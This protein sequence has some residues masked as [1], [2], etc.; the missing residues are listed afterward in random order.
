MK[1]EGLRT[2]YLMSAHGIICKRPRLQ[3]EH[4]VQ[5]GDTEGAR[6]LQ[7]KTNASE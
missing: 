1:G 6:G 5:T 4:R 3:L 7:H 2:A